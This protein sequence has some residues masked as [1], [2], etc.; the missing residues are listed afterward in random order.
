MREVHALADS[1]GVNR[2]RV[3]SW[4]MA[5]RKFDKSYKGMVFRFHPD[6][7][8]LLE[9]AYKC[10]PKPSAQEK[11]KIAKEIGVDVARVKH[12]Y[13]CARQRHDQVSYGR[14]SPQQK[15]GLLDAYKKERYPTKEARAE[16]ANRIGLEE[17][18][19]AHWFVAQRKR[20]KMSNVADLQRVKLEKDSDADMQDFKVTT[21]VKMDPINLD[22]RDQKK[23][24]E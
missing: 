8:L 5:K 10:D 22:G 2:R 1:M 9:T 4:F 14:L 19:V 18:R 24:F 15:D 6:Q 17:S 20:T 13:F 12:W 23:L 16:L 11:E 21:N 3:Y 7:T